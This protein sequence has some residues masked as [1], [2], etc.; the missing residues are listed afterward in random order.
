MFKIYF[1]KFKTAST[2]RNSVFIVLF[3]LPILI[4]LLIFFSED[5]DEF[6]Q[7]GNASYSGDKVQARCEDGTRMGGPGADNGESTGEG[8][9]YNVRTPLNYD[10]TIVH[11]LLMVY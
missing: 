10:P 2:F 9:K 7:M 11:P 1:D 4:T 6:S 5:N 3:F 8:I